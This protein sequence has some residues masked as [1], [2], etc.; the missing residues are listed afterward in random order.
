[1]EEWALKTLDEDT[2]PKVSALEE[3]TLA[4]RGPTASDNAA[5][6]AGALI[7]A[8]SVQK[9][10]IRGRLRIMQEGNVTIIKVQDN[11]LV[12]PSELAHIKKELYENLDVPNLRVLLDLK[13]I[14]RMSSSAAN[15]L[16]DFTDWLRK[17]GSTLAI[18][19]LKSELSAVVAD[20]TDIFQVKL[21]PTKDEALE[22]KW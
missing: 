15:M 8:M 18:C 3:L 2:G 22:A 19:R 16:A 9:G 20:L 12:E 5:S 13:N 10:V 1:L 4:S 6:A 14:L 21:Y 17:R 11:F 7:S